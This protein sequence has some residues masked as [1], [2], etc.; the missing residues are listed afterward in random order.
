MADHDE[1]RRLARAAKG[2][3]PGTWCDGGLFPSGWRLDRAYTFVG[4]RWSDYVGLIRRAA[5]VDFIAA[6]SPGRVL[7]L[8]DELAALSAALADCRR[9]CAGLADRVAAQSGLLAR[10]A[11]RA[12]LPPPAAEGNNAAR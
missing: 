2:E 8:L 9:V 7:A 6:A 10:Q 12:G 1:L 11:E 5:D 4:Q 3:T